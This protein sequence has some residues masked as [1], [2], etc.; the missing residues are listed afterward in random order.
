[1]IE[2]SAK[3]KPWTEAVKWAFIEERAE[4]IK[5]PV[6]V[7][8]QF[9][10]PKPKSAPKKRITHPDRKPDID[11]LIRSTLDALKQA[12][13]FEDDARVIQ[14]Y[15]GKVYPNEGEMALD[16]PGARIRIREVSG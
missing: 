10:L 8:L 16:V 2:S 9:T 6:S 3:V 15:A 4:I 12:G 7:L 13:A 11:K 5:G 14:L 1:M